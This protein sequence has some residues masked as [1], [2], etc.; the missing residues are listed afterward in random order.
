MN[1]IDK[2]SVINGIPQKTNENGN[3]E[4][5]IKVQKNSSTILR[6]LS[7]FILLKMKI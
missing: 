1:S 4:L 3:R 7:C 6:R 2:E 5:Y